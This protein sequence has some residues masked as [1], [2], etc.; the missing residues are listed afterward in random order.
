MI[1]PT[2]YDDARRVLQDAESYATDAPDQAI[3]TPAYARTI[4]S[5]GLGHALL[6]L[7]DELEAAR[8]SQS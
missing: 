6:A 4:A 3:G 7:C 1:E 8:H 5:I 2:A